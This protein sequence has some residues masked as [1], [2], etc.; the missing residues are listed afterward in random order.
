MSLI[1]FTLTIS[2]WKFSAWTAKCTNCLGKAGGI[3]A[4][5]STVLTAALLCGPAASFWYTAWK[6]YLTYLS[7]VC[8]LA[9]GASWKWGEIIPRSPT[10]HLIHGRVPSLEA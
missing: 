6:G 2:E 1:S 9:L 5:V 7:Q 10:S 4:R 8:S 3:R